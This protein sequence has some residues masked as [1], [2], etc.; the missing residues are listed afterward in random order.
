MIRTRVALLAVLSSLLAACGTAGSAHLQ[1]SDVQGFAGKS[2]AIVYVEPARP[3]AAGL[4]I[5][6]AGEVAGYRAYQRFTA[7]LA[8]Y[9]AGAQR[10]A[11]Q[12]RAYASIYEM[13][14]G[15]PWLK[16]AV[17][18]RIQDDSGSPQ[19]DNLGL[20]T[21]QATHADVV[22]VLHA[23]AVVHSY[24]DLLSVTVRAK[25]YTKARP[26][27]PRADQYKSGLL[28]GDG[29]L[30]NP[31]TFRG[32]GFPE[33]SQPL[34]PEEVQK[35]LDKVFARDGAALLRAENG[36][37]DALRPPLLYFFTGAGEPPQPLSYY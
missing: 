30:G 35:R 24:V 2:V 33:A 25:I 4:S 20:A 8:P 37:L 26:D 16:S 34:A 5:A 14:V 9:Q 23:G 17:W 28:A 15:V 1:A 3:V 11:V 10:L 18:K 32:F 27:S 12:D 21:A 19:M 29:D 13:L 7:E 22:V 36:A 31:G 6:P